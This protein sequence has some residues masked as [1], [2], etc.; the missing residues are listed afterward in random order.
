VVERPGEYTLS[1]RYGEGVE[2]PEVV[3][4]IH[5]SLGRLL[6]VLAIGAK[7]T[8]LAFLVALAIVLLRSGARCLEGSP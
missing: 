2:G 7:V 4:S 8:G 5:H 6:G 3:L 1:V